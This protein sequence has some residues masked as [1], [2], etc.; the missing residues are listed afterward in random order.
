MHVAV[1]KFTWIFVVFIGF[2]GK[3]SNTSIIPC[4]LELDILDYIIMYDAVSSTMFLTK[5]MSSER[6]GGSQ[7]LC[8]K[9]C[10]LLRSG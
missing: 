3:V 1:C 6:R 10:T 5:C 7:M 4:L 9:L 2:S 8:Q